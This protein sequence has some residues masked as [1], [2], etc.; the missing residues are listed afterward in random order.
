M[1]LNLSK[2][3]IEIIL[4]LRDEAS[5]KVKSFRADIKEFN[6]ATKDALQPILLMRQ[7]ALKASLAIG[8]ITLAAS[9]GIGFLQNYRKELESL[10]ITAIKLGMTS[11]ELSKKLYGFNIGTRMG[12]LGAAQMRA[13]NDETKGFWARLMTFAGSAVG[14]IGLEKRAQP[15]YKTMMS[16]VKS[17]SAEDQAFYMKRAREIAETQLLAED[18]VRKEKSPEALAANIE[19]IAKTKQ[20]AQ[21]ELDTKKYILEQEVKLFDGAA[22]DKELIAKY[23]SEAIKRI[24]EDRT[25]AYKN[26]VA[27]RLKSEGDSLGAM[28]IEQQN[29]LVEFKRQFGSD[30]EMVREFTAGQEAMRKEAELSYWGLKNET[31]IWHDNFVSLI[32]SA[33]S[34]FSDIFYNTITGQINNLGDVFTKFGQYVLKTLSDMITQ[35]LVLKAVVGIGNVISGW[36]T[37]TGGVGGSVVSTGPQSMGG[38]TFTQAWSPYHRGGIVRAHSGLAIDEVPIIAQRGERVLS[39][40]QNREY[41]AGVAGGSE[42]KNIIHN[43]YYIRIEATDALSFENLC[44]KNPGGIID[45]AQYVAQDDIRRRGPATRLSESKR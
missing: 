13:L 40:R 23:N 3:E 41:E 5:K 33:T 37:I 21:G 14:E 8:F 39:R 31:A 36:G 24:E 44:R 32:G 2:K 22:A 42:A 4:T 17:I 43:H 18:R 35:T 7:A 45:V 10:D 11:E 34:S 12:R 28:R 6:S 38:H 25:L 27:V 15:I 30:G 16:G 29:A 20:L 26:M 1:S 9:K 19:L